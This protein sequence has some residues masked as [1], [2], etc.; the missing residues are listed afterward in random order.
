MKEGGLFVL[1]AGERLEQ[2][3][4]RGIALSWWVCKALARSVSGIYACEVGFLDD[5]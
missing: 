2:S 1:K 3:S 4:V 5:G